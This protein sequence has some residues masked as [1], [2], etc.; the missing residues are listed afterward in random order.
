MINSTR[1][2]LAGWTNASSSEIL[3]F[4]SSQHD[5][6]VAKEWFPSPTEKSNGF[7]GFCS[8]AS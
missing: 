2:Y 6:A 7:S 8:K 1:V 4:I 3:D 5:L